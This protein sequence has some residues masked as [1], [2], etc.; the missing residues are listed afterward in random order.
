MSFSW[1]PIIDILAFILML[2]LLLPFDPIL[3]RNRAGRLV[4]SAYLKA[5]AFVGQ[6][7]ESPGD[8]DVLFLCFILFACLPLIPLGYLY[9][10]FF[11]APDFAPLFPA[12]LFGGCLFDLELA[13]AL[14]LL[15]QHLYSKRHFSSSL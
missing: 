7:I 8:P 3:P 9:A 5:N 10:T 4:V 11:I 12:F 15:A 6:A 2:A 1:Y 13:A 14:T